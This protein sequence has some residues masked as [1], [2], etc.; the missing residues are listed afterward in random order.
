MQQESKHPITKGRKKILIINWKWELGKNW[1][2]INAK[3]VA[4]YSAQSE[5]G[6]FFREFGVQSSDYC[7]DA[8]VL[9][10]SIYNDGALTQELLFQLLDKYMLDNNRVILLIHRPNAYHEDDIRNILARYPKHTDF[11]CILFEG[12]RDYI[13]YPVQEAGL[14]DDAGNFFMDGDL[15]VFDEENNLV[16]QPYFD[17]V[18]KY[19]EGEFEQKV[20][21]FKEDLLDHLFPLF[22]DAELNITRT[23]LTQ[24]LERDKD[25]LLWIRLKSF[26]GHHLIRSTQPEV[27]KSKSESTQESLSD[28]ELAEFKQKN[29]QKTEQRLLATFEKKT[30]TSYGFDECIIHLERYPDSLEAQFYR[31]TR[32]YCQDLFFTPNKNVITKSE[33]RE[34]TAKLDLLIKVIPGVIN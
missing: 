7:P 6:F 32:K 24:A 10:T 22:L 17:R 25:K 15:S 23:T 29:Q 19:Y 34:L 16:L 12:G 5:G 18:W 14:L 20:L 27:V 26:L 30:L 28:A 9:A 3:N 13:Y 1:V 2:H 31:E 8:L 33:L 4:K 11:R 21:V